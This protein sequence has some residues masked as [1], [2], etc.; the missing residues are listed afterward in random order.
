MWLH[1]DRFV[2]TQRTNL[3]VP[4]AARPKRQ[5][6]SWKR[7]IESKL[8]LAFV[9]QIAPL[10]TAYQHKM[11]KSADS[12][13]PLRVTNLAVWSR[14]PGRGRIACVCP[15]SIQHREANRS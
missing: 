15:R 14:L 6:Y 9:A 7:C 2:V 8:M 12:Q 11:L 5:I 13:R 4:P 10:L 3:S 1:D